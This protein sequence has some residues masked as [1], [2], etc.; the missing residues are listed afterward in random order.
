MPATPASATPGAD[1]AIAIMTSVATRALVAV[2]EASA[3]LVIVILMD[4]EGAW[5]GGRAFSSSL[6]F[7]VERRLTLL[8]EAS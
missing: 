8:Q 3:S 7:A 5:R 4:C 6:G 2:S 1:S